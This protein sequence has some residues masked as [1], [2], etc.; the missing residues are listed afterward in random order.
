MTEKKKDIILNELKVL[1]KIQGHPNIITL[2]D[3]IEEGSLLSTDEPEAHI[4]ASS[5]LEPLHGGE[6]IYHIKLCKN[7]S[8]KTS[9][10]FFKQLAS[11]VAHLSDRGFA[12]EIL[13]LGTSC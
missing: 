6:L 8:I 1:P 3:I 12:T 2:Y 13:S 4:F 5:C 10:Y 11:A 7:F 9:R